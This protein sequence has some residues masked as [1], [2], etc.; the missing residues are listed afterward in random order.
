MA[1]ESKNSTFPRVIRRS[2]LGGSRVNFLI[3]LL[4]IVVAFYC[5]AQYAPVAYRA[6]VFRDFMQETVNKAAF[7]PGQPITWIES[8]LRSNARENE[9]PDNMSINIQNQNGQL[10]A[11]VQWVKPIPLPGYVYEYKFDHTAKSGTF[12]NPH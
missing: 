3:V 10:V 11:R 9:L 12:I 4:V 6:L 8:Q 5:G 7:P 2:E 1:I